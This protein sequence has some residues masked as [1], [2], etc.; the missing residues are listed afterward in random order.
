MYL[1][2]I[3]SYRHGR[4]V[5][6]NALSQLRTFLNRLSHEAQQTNS[7]ITSFDPLELPLIV[8]VSSSLDVLQETKYYLSVTGW[9]VVVQSAQLGDDVL[10]DFITAPDSST[11]DSTAL[12]TPPPISPSLPSSPLPASLSIYPHTENQWISTVAILAL[13]LI[14]AFITLLCIRRRTRKVEFATLK[15]E[16]H[17]KNTDLEL[18]L[19]S[20]SSEDEQFNASYRTSDNNNKSLTPPLIFPHTIHSSSSQPSSYRSIDMPVDT[21]NGNDNNQTSRR[22]SLSSMLDEV[23]NRFHPATFNSKPRNVEFDLYNDTASIG[24]VSGIDVCSDSDG[25]DFSLHRGQSTSHLL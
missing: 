19:S 13:V 20:E 22:N 5:S 24:G 9:D 2:K 4:P 15:S 18:D 1:L 10:R 3:V 12:D 6:P 14:S 16:L 7:V 25:R 17:S 23:E 21:E 8:A 11:H